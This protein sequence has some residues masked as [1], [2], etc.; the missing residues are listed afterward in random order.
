MPRG[1]FAPSP[2]GDLHAGSAR[3]A[4]V[5]WLAARHDGSSFLL[6]IEDI[7]GP[8]MVPG[9]EQRIMEDLRWLGLDWDDEPIRQRERLRM[10]DQAL[11]RLKEADLVYPC[12]CSRADVARAASAPHG[13][14]SGPA[15]PGI[16]RQ[17]TK[18]EVAARLAS[19]RR[20]SLR[21]R[22]PDREVCFEDA[23]HGRVWGRSD[24]FIVR[25]SDGLHAYQLAVVVDDIAMGIEEVVRGDDLLDSTPRQLLLY[26]ALEA[27]PPRFA[28]L[29]LVVGADGERLAKRHGSITIRAMRESGLTPGRVVGQLASSLGLCDKGAELMPDELR[30]AF[31]FE[32]ITRQPAVWEGF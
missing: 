16:C 1:R 22:A 5:A 3:T 18:R 10:Y 24:D 27:K 13:G 9:V 2:S 17:L 23:V 25:R 7:D 20:P 4:L 6:R 30:G 19:G 12:F 8:R 31:P 29:P 15:Y 14:E 26:E 21:F 32:R 11:E 28:H